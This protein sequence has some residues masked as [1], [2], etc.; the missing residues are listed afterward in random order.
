MLILA[1]FFQQD[2]EPIEADAVISL[3]VS[4][5]FQ[6]ILGFGGAFTDAAG[7]NIYGLP[8]EIQQC[9]MR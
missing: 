4:R 6:K 5:K 8:V 1:Y 2:N 3:D 9:K 7:I